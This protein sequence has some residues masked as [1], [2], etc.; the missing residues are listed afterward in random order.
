L[1]EIGLA[2]FRQVVNVQNNCGV[3]RSA[4]FAVRGFALY[5]VAAFVVRFGNR[6]Q[7][8]VILIGFLFE[9]LVGKLSSCLMRI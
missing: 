3:V 9:N 8:E 6:L 7:V 1:V 2:V 5:R 4:L